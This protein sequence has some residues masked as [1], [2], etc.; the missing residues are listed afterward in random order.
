MTKAEKDVPYRVYARIVGIAAMPKLFES[1]KA[2]TPEQRQLLQAWLLEWD[3]RTEANV[4]YILETDG[5][6]MPDEVQR[7]YGKAYL[8]ALNA[9]LGALK[10]V[11]GERLMDEVFGSIA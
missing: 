1:L 5:Y 11:E 4:F 6:R 10:Q 7:L 3:P 8:K 2:Y 9:I